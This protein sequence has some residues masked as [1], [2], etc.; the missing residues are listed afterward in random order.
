MK[1][2][3]KM[4]L[5]GLLTVGMVLSACTTRAAEETTG[6]EAG[7]EDIYLDIYSEDYASVTENSKWTS[8]WEKASGVTDKVEEKLWKTWTPEAQKAEFTA[9][10]SD[11]SAGEYRFSI[12][13]IGGDMDT[14]NISVG[15]VSKE[16][17]VN[18]WSDSGQYHPTVTDT[19]K[20]EEKGNL[21]VVLKLSYKDG[22]WCNLDDIKLQKKAGETELRALEKQKLTD[23]VTE[24]KGLNESRYME[25]T[26]KSV[27]EAMAEAEMVLAK[28][29]ASAADYT[30]AYKKLTSA[31][32][33]LME[34]D[35]FVNKV[36]GLSQDFMRGVDISS[37][38]S[39]VESGATFKDSEGKVLD[40]EG[41][42]KLLK[43]SGVNWVRIRVWNDPYDAN[44]NGYGA[45]NNDIEKAVKM[46]KW[47]TAAGLRALIDF[48][49]SDFWADPDRQLAPK[50][51]KDFTIEQKEEALYRFTKESLQK[52]SDAG[53]DVGMV[54]VGNETNSGL[55]GEKDWENM[56]KLF[57]AGV[58]AV[59][60]AGKNI[61][62][63]VHF[64]DPQ[65]PD[66]LIGLAENL[67]KY[68]VDYDVFASSYYPATHG[69][70]ENITKVLSDV[71]KTYGKKV[72]V[73]ETSWAWT[74]EDGDGHSQSF[75]V[76]TYADYA[77]SVQGQATEIRDVVEAVNQVEGGAG[78]G[79]FYW[80]PAWIPAAYAYD[81]EGKRIESIYNANKEKWEK[82]GSGVASSFSAEYAE[83]AKDW[84]GGSVKDNEAFFDF[85]GNPL[86]SLTVFKDIYEGRKAPVL[87]VEKIK[88]GNVEVLLESSDVAAE[89]SNIQ[90][91]LPKTVTGIYND[92]SRKEFAVTWKTEELAEKITSFGN[93]EISGTTSYTDESG[94]EITKE[95]ACDISVFP[96][97]ILK[98]GD[99]EAL[100]DGSWTLENADTTEIKW[101]DTPMRGEGAL[102]FWN[103]KEVN[104]TMKQ[105]VKAEQAGYYCASMYVQGA[106]DAANVLTISIKN[107]IGK[108]SASKEIPMKGWANWQTE[109]TDSVSAEA[110]D[111]LQVLITVKGAAGAWG[112]IDDVFLYKTNQAPKPASDP[113]Q[114]N[115]TKKNTCKK[116]TAV[117]K[118]YTI[119][120]KG[121]TVK[122]VFTITAA[123]N[124][125]KTTDKVTV[126]VKNKKI[127]K[128]TKTTLQKGKVTVTVKGVK[129]GK[130]VLN[131]KVGTKSAKTKITVKK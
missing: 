93:Y 86:P 24:C 39:V 15:E 77:I 35:I 32:N 87:R 49:Y 92:S 68:E 25:R 88:N 9:V 50:A 4:A 108:S 98:N 117:K 124:S 37:Y 53:V 19:V 43:E 52:L 46:G 33:K 112:S 36:E 40:D 72:M 38:V 51:W 21:K 78:I 127:A 71:A 67:K 8:A 62:A 65:V 111:E 82:Y 63:A 41:F 81:E 107:L 85:E 130:T 23:I 2:T 13:T 7:N 83:D 48:H 73:A 116:V 100:E 75:D 60:E 104:F 14:S 119:Q 122:A 26:W 30:S 11:L 131:I 58:K 18:A 95:T 129:K 45:G 20:V 54:Q 44:G 3:W 59:R 115:D 80:E 5:G 29:E 99:F 76:G 109:T 74:T 16:L 118:T 6:K 47:A 1:K 126:K 27:S 89:I 90:A 94:K 123:D 56:A 70:M 103:E 120:K 102:H 97:S 114:E 105:T 34:K 61:L 106:E 69:T 64:T 110:G 28:T 113:V 42:F 22:G 84:Y 128:M 101:N 10:F 91:K 79:V 12:T 57:K 31:K 66:K 17:L 55:A 96:D 121:K 125:K